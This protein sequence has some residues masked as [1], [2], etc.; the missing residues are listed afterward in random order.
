MLHHV[1]TQFLETNRLVLRRYQISD[2]DDMYRNWVT[3]PEVC[4]F[5]QWKPH[6]NIDET[7]TLL[8][9]W[10]SEY[11]KSDTYH[12]VIVLKK[13]AEAIGYLYLADI[14]DIN[15]SLSI[16]YAL[17]RKHWNKGIMTEA[18]NCVMDFA[19]TV[20]GAQ[21]IY[22]YHHKDNPASGRV[23]Q[24]SGLRHIKTAY[25]E[26]LEHEQISGEYCYYEITV[27]DWKVAK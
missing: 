22:S 3:D 1:G 9:G 4:R 25:K 5:W 26:I 16:H 24:K 20:L 8:S 15:N 7:K 17:S 10:I 27:S 21:R 2:A 19:F 12:W 11:E 6:K 18:C 23:L 13:N 14:D